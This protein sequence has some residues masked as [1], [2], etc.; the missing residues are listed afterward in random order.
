MV[1]TSSVYGLYP[2]RGVVRARRTFCLLTP[3]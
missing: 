1:V 3:F 2:D